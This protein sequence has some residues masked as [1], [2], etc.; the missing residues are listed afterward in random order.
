MGDIM[1]GFKPTIVC[2]PKMLPS[3]KWMDAAR[4]ARTINPINHAPVERLALVEKDFVIQPQHIAVVTTKYW[5]AGGVNLTVG[6]LDNP[7]ANLRKRILEH[8]NAWAKTANVKFVA[9]NSDPKVRIARVKDGY[10]SYVGTDILTIPP[11]GPTMN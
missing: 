2:T 8:M 9:S 11:D 1:K 4:I 6:F 10:W 3:D 7:P 5:G